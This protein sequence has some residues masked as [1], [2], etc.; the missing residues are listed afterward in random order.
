MNPTDH[1]ATVQRKPAENNPV[2]ELLLEQLGEAA[3][4]LLNGRIER[5]NAP[6][7]RIWQRAPDAGWPGRDLTELFRVGDRVRL[8]GLLAGE[9][10]GALDL[11]GLRS[12][13]RPFPVR[14]RA[15]RW[16]TE[17]P[18]RLLLWCRDLSEEH[19]LDRE[20]M[21]SRRALQSLSR[22]NQVVI[23]ARSEEQ[24]MQ[25]I[26]RE[27]VESGGY[28]MAWIGLM[29]HDA[30]KSVKPVAAVGEGA[31]AVAD[32]RISWGD[33][34]R[35]QGLTG[36]AIRTGRREC[37]RGTPDEPR[38]RPWREWSARLGIRSGASFPLLIEGE[39]VGALTLYAA[40][41][42]SFDDREV[43]LLTELA[44]ELAFGI[45]TQRAEVR[46]REV[47]AERRRTL[48]EAER[49]RRT[50][51]GVL[52]DQKL[53]E[54]ARRQSEDRYR[55]IVNS[56][57][58]GMALIALPGNVEEVNP[59]LCQI[60]GYTEAEL[61]GLS[62][63][64]FTHPEDQEVGQVHIDAL[65][66][67]EVAQC[68][69]EKRYLHKSGAVVWVQIHLS[70]VDEPQGRRT[71]VVSQVVDITARKVAEASL[72]Q[73]AERL[74]LALQASRLGIWRVN[75]GSGTAEWDDRTAEIFDL[76]AD[77]QDGAIE[78]LLTRVETEDRARLHEALRRDSPARRR[79]HVRLRV[80]GSS[81]E[82]R[83]VELHG[84]VHGD[85]AGQPEW[86][87]VVAGDVTELL[88]AATEAERLRT[89]LQ[90]AQKMESLGRLAAGVAH[91]FNN[92]LT[93]ING[94]VQLASTSLE[95]GHEA[96]ELLEHAQRGAGSARDLV[97]RILDFSR[98]SPQQERVPVN[99]VQLVRDTAALVS[100]GLPSR[101]SLGV[102]TSA[103]EL[104]VL[105]DGGQLQQVLMNLCTNGAHAI[106]G[107]SGRVEIAL[108]PV[109]FEGAGETVPP[110]DYIRLTVT[111]T[112][113]GMTAEQLARIF[114]PFYTTK[115]AGQ[116]TGLGMS[117]I[118]EIVQAHRGLVRARSQVGE[119]S[120]FEVFLPRLPVESAD[121]PAALNLKPAV[122][123]GGRVLVVDDDENVGTVVCGTLQR[124]GYRT[125]LLPSGHAALDRLRA[126]GE[127]VDLLMT[128]VV[129]PGMNG[130][131]LLAEVHALRPELPAVIMAG[132]LV[133][134]PP[135]G[136]DGRAV[137]LLKKP[138]TLHEIQAAVAAA[139]AN[140]GTGGRSE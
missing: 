22:C 78:Q 140:S 46:R 57:P 135:P 137:P 63:R 114:E 93:G 109:Q 94:F 71:H 75:L 107:E 23:H 88:T 56:S 128:D 42:E 80:R 49:A 20:L 1:P 79:F 102:R 76:A 37:Q 85:R 118:Q 45:Q 4:V 112:G 17:A 96:G 36:Q 26:C 126:G 117:I 110:G 40:D 43:A 47:E 111:D 81:A 104:I 58:I 97:R 5:V 33:G 55:N 101:V 83:H 82:T 65:R 35:G 19:R 134:T 121:P 86:A 103:E 32:L 125:E 7:A 133:Q 68:A 74:A 120:C 52:E 39:T 73:A 132:N 131:A 91:D 21:H 62:A 99:L 53:A 50:L 9:T 127:P 66:S 70:I 115:K 84:I 24:L 44:R 123:P 31:E 119:G 14:V 59:A 129:M 77:A 60:L 106:G 108:E 95:P 130:M 41:D 18:G 67:G 69:Y 122:R 136:P 28:R 92:L 139:L 38:H 72:D 2:P 27:I 13:G 98:A 48:R 90:Q 138:F 10:E 3:A 64:D 87:I 54:Q 12:D 30:E 89:Q 105:A 34:E 11:Q 61:L 116:G 100:A 51:L 124:L 25:D 29:Q 16:E 15:A 8:S 6:F 113:C